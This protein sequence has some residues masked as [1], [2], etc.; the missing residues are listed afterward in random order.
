MSWVGKILYCLGVTRIKVMP[1]TN[2]QLRAYVL[3]LSPWNP[4]TWIIAVMVV[5]GLILWTG[6]M[7]SR[8]EI[9]SLFTFQDI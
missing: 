7:E 6:L 2:G 8:N 4:L 1:E 3:P 5:V 9:K